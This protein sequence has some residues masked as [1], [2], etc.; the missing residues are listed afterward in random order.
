MEMGAD[1]LSDMSAGIFS[2]LWSSWKVPWAKQGYCL[3]EASGVCG[4]LSFSGF[5][6]QGQG[7]GK[8]RVEF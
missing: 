6:L 3:P 4:R 8:L 2:W 7:Q 5:L 1:W